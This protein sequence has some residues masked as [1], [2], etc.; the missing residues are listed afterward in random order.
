MPVD[1]SIFN[2]RE[3]EKRIGSI[4]PP[5]VPR[6]FDRNALSTLVCV[7]VSFIDPGKFPTYLDWMMLESEVVAFVQAKLELHYQPGINPYNQNDA[8]KAW[9]IEAAKLSHPCYF[10]HTSPGL[11]LEKARD[12]SHGRGAEVMFWDWNLG[13]VLWRHPDCI[14]EEMAD[15]A[16]ENAPQR[17]LTSEE[18]YEQD[19]G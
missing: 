9:R 3:I 6:L 13:R 8:A 18:L 2:K 4:Q 7:R 14:A 5:E 19:G 1:D 15:V 17:E 10:W 11:D 16:R 12:T